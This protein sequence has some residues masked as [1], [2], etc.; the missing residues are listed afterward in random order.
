M[1]V[2]LVTIERPRAKGEAWRVID[3]R[4][5]VRFSQKVGPWLL[6]VPAGRPPEDMAARWVHGLMDHEFKVMPGTP[7]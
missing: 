4:H 2:T 1:L 7:G 3:K 6:V 5:S